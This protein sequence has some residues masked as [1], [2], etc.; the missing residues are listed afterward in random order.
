MVQVRK[1]HLHPDLQGLYGP[2]S[3][4][5]ALMKK[6]WFRKFSTWAG[7]KALLGKDIDGL[8]CEQRYID[9]SDGQWQIRTRIYRPQNV[10][11]KLP[12]MIYIHGGGY[13]IGSPETAHAIIERFVATRPC[14]VIAPDYRKAGTAP[15]PAGFNDC[16]ETLLWAK[17][18]ADEL[19]IRDTGFIVAGHSAGGGLTAAV[20]LKA[21]DTRE[22]D[23]AFQ[24]PIYPMIDDTQ[25]S[26]QERAMRTPVWDT[27]L[28]EIGWNA[29]LADLHANGEEIPAYAAPA[30]NTD[31]T[32]FPPTISFVGDKEP[33]YAEDVAYVDALRAAGVDVAFK[34]FPGCFHAFDMMAKGIGDVAKDFTYEKYGEFYDRYCARLDEVDETVQL[35]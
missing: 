7:D 11:G 28:N 18:N 6:E 22:V 31:Y 15:F 34:E 23:L 9:S 13:I 26:D 10:T 32:N 29:Y 16:Y 30:R 33:F 35:A 12:A 1:E 5:A 4:M 25:P 20:T 3:V 21:R 19:G 2:L 27:E 17:H 14:V 8:D 24:M